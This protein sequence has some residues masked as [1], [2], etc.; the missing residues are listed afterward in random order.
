M[1]VLTKADFDDMI[2]NYPEQSDIVMTNMLL[3]YGLTRDGEEICT[4]GF[5][6]R[7]DE[8]GYAQL[9]AAIQVRF[10]LCA[11][12]HMPVSEGCFQC[13]VEHNNH[14]VVGFRGAV[15]WAFPLAIQEKTRSSMQQLDSTHGA[16]HYAYWST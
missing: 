9:R 8:E 12:T 16:S 11:N 5:D 1:L 10:L 15:C 7:A 6:K 13:T 4:K 3:Q 2:S 14:D